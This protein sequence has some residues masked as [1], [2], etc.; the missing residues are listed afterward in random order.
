VCPH[1]ERL[2]DLEM[3]RLEAV[4]R[5][6][7]AALPIEI[8]LR[9]A[10]VAIRSISDFLRDAVAS[11]IAIP[12]LLKWLPIADDPAVKETIVRALSIPSARPAATRPLIQQFRKL[13]LA[14]NEGI[15]WA[16]GN[17]LSVIADDSAFDAIRD[18]VQDRQHGRAREMLTVALG[19]MRNPET[20]NLLIRLLEDDQVAGHALIAI[21]KLGQPEAIA[22]VRPFLVHEKMW[23][24]KEAKKT[25]NKLTKVL[26]RAPSKRAH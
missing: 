9:L 18:L 11:D 2:A 26:E 12:I 17:A 21:R 5:S 14:E 24:R 13:P 4:E 25:M 15:K 1:Q 23:V 16:I 7:L 8:E 10:G 22:H 19:N 3:Q 6:K 20:V